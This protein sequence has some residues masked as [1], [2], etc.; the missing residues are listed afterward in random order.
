MSTGGDINDKLASALRR[1]VRT[2]LATLLS[3]LVIGVTLALPAALYL[4]LTNLNGLAS[5]LNAE[6]QISIFLTLDASEAEV[7]VCRRNLK[8]IPW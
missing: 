6:P 7:Q 1:V 4:I 3:I 2:P 8:L 5:R